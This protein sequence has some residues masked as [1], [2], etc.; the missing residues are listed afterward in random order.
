MT[1]PTHEGRRHIL[2]ILAGGA[3]GAIGLSAAGF[4]SFESPI[5]AHAAT[6]TSELSVPLRSL[7][8]T[9]QWLN[10]R[11]LAPKDIQGKVV[12]VNFWTYSCINS[13]RMLP[14]TRA[15]AEK[16]KDQGLLVIGVETPEFVF[17]KSTSNVRKALVSLGISY[18]VA[19]DNDFAIWQAFENQA[20]PA[21]Y[22]IGADGQIRSHVVGEGGYDKSEQLIK[23]LLSEVDGAPV[24]R[25]YSII[26]GVGLQAPADWSD[27]GSPETYVG[28][29]KAEN[30]ASP[31]GI[32]EDIRNFY[33]EA[34]ML[35]LNHWCLAGPWTMGR[36]FA[37]PAGYSSS[38][39][40]RFHARDLHLVLGRSSQGRPLQF[41]VTLDGAPPDTDHGNDVT[42]AGRGSL[43]DERLYQ[44]I[45]QSRPVVDRTFTMEFFDADARVYDFTFG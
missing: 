6:Q 24:D 39:S 27:L 14:Y 8:G 19:I 3:A 16:Y 29:E 9:S 36:E 5:V 42:A 22:F 7:L 10:T 12:V 43:Q 37:A 32:R 21:L 4:S 28:Y 38:I 35:P 25:N 17:E 34:S 41:R 45:R 13:L 2:Q 26:K 20:W 30:F 31:G 40:F 33:G 23:Q 11:P 15:W 18:P 44:L 1:N